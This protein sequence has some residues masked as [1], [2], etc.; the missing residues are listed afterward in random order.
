M[1]LYTVHGLGF[2]AIY[3]LHN[4]YIPFEAT[5]KGARE[6]PKCCRWSRPRAAPTKGCLLRGAAVAEFRVQGL[7][8][9][10]LGLGFSLL[11]LGF[12]V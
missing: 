11:G 3:P 4:P 8:C 10:F 9:R 2:G 7:G 12:R 5:L 1:F 6:A